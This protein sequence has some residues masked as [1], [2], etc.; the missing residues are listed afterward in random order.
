MV[1]HDDRRDIIAKSLV[2]RSWEN[3]MESDLR[4]AR[5]AVFGSLGFVAIAVAVLVISGQPV[6]SNS[7][8]E[9]PEVAKEGAS[10]IASPIAAGSPVQVDIRKLTFRPFR[11][12]ISEGD[13][14]VWTNFDGVPHTV[15]AKGE[16]D[17]GRIDRNGVYVQIFSE[18][19]D[20]WYE[21]LYHKDM[22]A[23]V[24]VVDPSP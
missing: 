13:G 9:T 23:V 6:R 16:F 1:H 12:S 8:I 5:G 21:C 4:S 20:Y 18:S 19:G 24:E 14:V 22:V 3:D 2:R 17:S 15:T 11:V 7:A 10:P